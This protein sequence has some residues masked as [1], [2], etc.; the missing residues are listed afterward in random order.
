LAAIAWALAL[1]ASE[2]LREP[3]VRLR[4]STA[5]LVGTADAMRW[6]SLRRWTRRADILFGALPP[7]AATLRACAARIATF[8]AAHVP[9]S[10][11]PV[12]VDAFHGAS[13]CKPR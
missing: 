2:R 9:I 8:V 10:L 4:T 3:E 11:G 1:W 12:P 6:A 5:K 13:F 7:P